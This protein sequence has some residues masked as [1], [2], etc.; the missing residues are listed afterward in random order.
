MTVVYAP[1]N[2]IHPAVSDRSHAQSKRSILSF[3]VGDLVVG[4]EGEGVVAGAVG[5]GEFV[6]VEAR[7]PGIA[8][9]WVVANDEG[10]G[11]FGFQVFDQVAVAA[12]GT[13]E[14]IAEFGREDFGIFFV[15]E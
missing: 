6:G 15:G 10:E 1:V 8:G 9:G 3:E 13:A 11:F 12:A 2:S 7:D 4:G 5:F 14:V